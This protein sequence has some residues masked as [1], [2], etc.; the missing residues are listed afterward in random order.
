MQENDQLFYRVAV[1]SFKGKETLWYRLNKSFGDLVATS[2]DA[3]L[4]GLLIPAM[5]TG[6][7]IH[8]DGEVSE[9]LLYNLS[10]P[11][12]TLLR[13]VIPSLRP[14]R[15]FADKICASRACPPLGVATGFSGGI[16]SYC[17]LADNYHGNVL[18][19]FKITHLLFNN[20]GSH[21]KDGEGLFQK[22]S[23]RLAPSAERLG[24]P[25]VMVNSNLGT[26]YGKGLGFQQTHTPRNGS[27]ALLLQGG[28]GRYMYASAFSYSNVFVGRAKEMACTDTI[29]LPL[30]STETLDAF[31]VGSEYTRVEKT[32]RVAEIPESYGSLDVCTDT[33][34]DPGYTNCSKCPKCLRT[35]ATLEIAGL[36]ELYAGSFNLDAYRSRRSMFFAELLGS[37]D[38]FHK[39]IIQFSRERNYPYPVASRLLHALRIPSLASLSERIQCKLK[40]P[41]TPQ[42]GKRIFQFRRY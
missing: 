29:S 20:V 21:G 16:D 37:R 27:V 2:C 24:L 36:L 19:G 31:S 32:L 7:D 12:Q 35:L 39:E 13:H 38:P 33:L 17:A 6:E 3:P 18:D 42:V 1:E 14:V 11:Y 28:I 25:F 23:E 30:L 8:I 5:A 9:R 41:P 4:V 22:R 40:Q 10:R 34:P 15:I 26:F